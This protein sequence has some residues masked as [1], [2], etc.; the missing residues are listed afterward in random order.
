MPQSDEMY[1]RP[2]LPKAHPEEMDPKEGKSQPNAPDIPEL[3]EIISDLNQGLK[4]LIDG[5]SREQKNIKEQDKPKPK[6]KSLDKSKPK[7]HKKSQSEPNKQPKGTNKKPVQEKEI[8]PTEEKH[9]DY[10]W[11]KELDRAR[12]EEAIFNPYPYGFPMLDLSRPCGCL[13]NTE[14]EAK[15]DRWLLE[16]WPGSSFVFP[17]EMLDDSAEQDIDM[18]WLKTVPGLEKLND[19]LNPRLFPES[20]IEKFL[21]FD[22]KNK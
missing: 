3:K 2:P 12:R 14:E 20:P 9:K 4:K 6:R 5:F 22:E 17:Q 1:I 19:F 18:W 15:K 13:Y 8:K 16:R 10:Q 7:K 21:L 11:D